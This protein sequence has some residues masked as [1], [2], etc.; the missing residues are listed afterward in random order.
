MQNVQG[1]VETIKKPKPKQSR[2][3]RAWQYVGDYIGGVGALWGGY[4]LIFL[5]YLIIK[6]LRSRSLKTSKPNVAS[7]TLIKC[8]TIVPLVFFGLLSPFTKIEANWPAMHMMGLAIW[9]AASKPINPKLILGAFTFHVLLLL[10]LGLILYKPELL[11]KNR[12]NRLLL[13]SRGFQA[14]GDWAQLNS[15]RHVIAVDS[16]QLKS[17]LR[18]HAPNV[19]VVQW[20]GFTRDSEYTRGRQ[21]DL[22]LERKIL[23]QNNFSVISTNDTPMT[24][25]GFE[26]TSFRGIRVCAD[27]S[28]GIFSETEVRLPCEKGLRE[29]WITDY[30]AQK[31]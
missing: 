24:I 19:D 1:F 20:P 13:E 8:S 10:S 29:W 16:Y 14:L 5:F 25:L 3:E 4:A 9:L 2:L 11:P 23:D 12:N 21:N 26:A 30:K 6:Q 18:F 22:I 28:I 17:A 27:G 15:P 31:P 7:L